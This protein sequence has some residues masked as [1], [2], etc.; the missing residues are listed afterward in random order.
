MDQK[1]LNIIGAIVAFVG[2]VVSFLLAIEYFGL[3]T[4]NIA[5]GACSALGGDGSCTKVAE[6]KYSFITFPVLGNV[7][8]AAF[9]FGFYATILYL[10]GLNVKSGNELENKDRINVIFGLS[11]LALLLDLALLTISIWVI[12]TVCQLC[13]ITYFVTIALI[14]ISYVLLKTSAISLTD[15]TRSIVSGIGTLFVV[16]F[17]NFSVAFATSK[18]IAS[19]KSN[20][21]STSSDMDNAEITNKIK[22]YEEGQKLNIDLTGSASIGKANAPITIVKYADFNCGHCLHT[23]H[24]L[25]KVLADYDGMVK[26]VYKNFP[27]DGTC[28]RLVSEPR[29]GA[30]SCI[31][32]MASICADKQGKFAE[33]YHGLYENTEKGITHSASTVL[34][35]GNTLGLNTNQLKA[36]MSSKEAQ[37]QLNKEIDVAEK[38][39]IQ[40]TPSLYINDKRIDSGTPN[41]VF[42]KALL[43]RLINKL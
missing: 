26:V 18:M 6:S 4:S 34:N 10:F 29:P 20:S 25:Q 5:E 32:A 41:P 35:L 3:G 37:T 17:F 2:I 16:F 9:G 39:N 43:D 42:L 19:P 8:I 33:M 31:A 11:I 30:S 7:P 24:I 28:N 21:L 1:K 13:A 23:S 14:G 22:I 15:I 12:G 36:C 38:L 40:A 27:L